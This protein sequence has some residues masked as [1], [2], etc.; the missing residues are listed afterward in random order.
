MS[1]PNQKVFITFKSKWALAHLCGNFVRRVRVKGYQVFVRQPHPQHLGT[2]WLFLE[3]ALEQGHFI[4]S[5]EAALVNYAE[6]TS[7]LTIE[8]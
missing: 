5:S 2:T 6:N 4:G 8:R 1:S 7:A 3:S